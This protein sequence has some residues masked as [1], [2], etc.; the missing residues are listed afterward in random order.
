MSDLLKSAFVCLCACVCARAYST[1]P[2]R[3]RTIYD[4]IVFVCALAYIYETKKAR[5][6]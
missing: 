6:H 4:C 3:A 2:N 5:M 1:T